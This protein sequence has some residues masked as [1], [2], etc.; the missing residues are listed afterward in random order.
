[1]GGALL[2]TAL[3]L[4]A[5]SL[6]TD[7][8]DLLHRKSYVSRPMLLVAAAAALSPALVRPLLRLLGARGRLVRAQAAAA[9]RRTAA[10]AAPV[11]AVVALAGALPGA[12]ATV[13]AAK[14]AEIARATTADLV[15]T[16]AGGLAPAELSRVRTT[17]G[18]RTA[19]AVTSTQITT[20]EDGV[21]LIR[22]QGWAVDPATLPG[23]VRLPDVAGSLAGLDDGSIVVTT[24]WQRHT[25]GETV[26][27]WL[28]D[29]TRRRLRI[30]AVLAQG[31]GDN[32][33]YV[34]AHNA[35]P[36]AAPAL[37]RIRLAPGA[38][39]AA[40]SAQLRHAVPGADVRTGPAW[41]RATAPHSTA[42]TRLG[43]ALTLGIALLYAVLALA[44]AQAVSTAARAREL[45]L[46]RRSG[47][48]RLQ[49]LRLTAAE[50]LLPVAVGAALGLLTAG[51][52]LA[53]LHAALARLA[54][55][56]PLT[57]PWQELTLATTAC[58]T[59][60]ITATTAPVLRHLLRTRPRP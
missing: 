53:T 19:S 21:A 59:A 58:A 36:G 33:V 44:T 31:T 23:T 13:N 41:V 49:L 7:P 22:S 56:A 50:S 55:P 25:V 29:G 37:V 51:L 60:A 46:L 27:V 26:T 40:V 16:A 18:V 32:G 2:L 45:T 14:S 8:G 10:V 4:A 47:A 15:L 39:P 42:T 54:T 1:M 28:A 48:T 9:A 3:G 43:L 35:P 17:P 24:E 11:V 12:V 34:T 5:Y 52:H 6:A 57:L 38:S 20:L 30:A